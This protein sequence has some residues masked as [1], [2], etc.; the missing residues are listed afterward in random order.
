[1]TNWEKRRKDFEALGINPDDKA[2]IA[3]R[4]GIRKDGTLMLCK[5]GTCF[6]C[7][8]FDARGDC[9]QLMD[10][11]LDEEA[12]PGKGKVKAKKKPRI[13]VY[14]DGNEVIAKNLENGKIGKA[15][16]GK[17]DTFDFDTGAYIALSRLTGYSAM[18]PVM[19]G[20]IGLMERDL[21]DFEARVKAMMGDGD[22]W[23]CDESFEQKG[24]K[25]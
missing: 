16:C 22:M 13:V 12:E 24:G 6:D 4:V 3:E 17:K 20:D 2:K 1:M 14:Q 21:K 11:W 19:L 9:E 7:I 23:S 8:F 15:T 18:L 25:K 5:L 10:K